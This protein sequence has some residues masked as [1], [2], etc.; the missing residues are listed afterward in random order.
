MDFILSGAANFV[1][2]STE[3]MNNVPPNSL[4]FHWA[5]I[6]KL[7]GFV[8]AEATVTNMTV[9]YIEASGKLLY[10]TVISPRKV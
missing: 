9:T 5:E 4:K 8:Y 6:T 1:D 3:H 7:G 2:E 10:Q